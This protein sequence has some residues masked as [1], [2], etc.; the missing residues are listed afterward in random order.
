MRPH[1]RLDVWKKSMNLVV[2]IYK[3]TSQ[4]PN[5][6]KFGIISQM[7]RSAVSIP[8]NIAE[9]AARESNK[10]FRNFLSISQGSSAELETQL[11]L[12]NQLKYI[13]EQELN[14]ML[15]LLSDISKMIIGLR[16]S[17]QNR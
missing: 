13:G 5:E 7:R 14:K 2:E 6:E 4:F 1:H 8:S 3:I 9:G 10:E 17:L 16:K 15:N 11:I 12:C